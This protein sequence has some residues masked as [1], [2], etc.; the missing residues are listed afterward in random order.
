MV[1]GQA[2]LKDPKD[3]GRILLSTWD[4]IHRVKCRSVDA[5]MNLNST[6]P[7]L[8]ELLNELLF[9]MGKACDADVHVCSQMVHSKTFT[10]QV[11]GLPVL[12]RQVQRH[13]SVH[14]GGAS[15]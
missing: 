11:P 9:D 6:Q 8:L 7:Q 15:V 5:H 2:V 1:E 12:H 13:T 10:M 4:I 3:Q 14:Y